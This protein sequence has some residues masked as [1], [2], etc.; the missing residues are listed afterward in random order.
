MYVYLFIYI[1]IR[2]YV[3][4]YEC[5]YDQ[6]PR[7]AGEFIIPILVPY[8]VSACTSTQVTP[9]K[10]GLPPWD[11]AKPQQVC[12]YVYISYNIIIFIDFFVFIKIDVYR[13]RYFYVQTDVYLSVYI[14]T[15]YLY[16]KKTPSKLS[17]LQ[18]LHISASSAICFSFLRSK[19]NCKA[20]WDLSFYWKKSCCCEALQLSVALFFRGKR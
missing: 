17:T 7:D 14:Y 20:L 1:Y 2:K 6:I 5:M 3:C 10:L 13:Y 12:A 19:S 15:F 16:T 18:L 9:Q 8:R 11:G 4:M